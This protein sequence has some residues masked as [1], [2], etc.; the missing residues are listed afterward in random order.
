VRTSAD[1]CDSTVTAD[2]GAAISDVERIAL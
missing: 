2:R 1:V